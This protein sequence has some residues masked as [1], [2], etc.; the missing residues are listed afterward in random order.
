MREVEK[1]THEAVKYENPSEHGDKQCWRCE[2]YITPKEAAD[3]KP[4]CQG[5]QRPIAAAG[6][7]I[8]FDDILK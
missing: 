6:Y 7:C 1:R 5:V 2:H 4:A 3:G 8:R